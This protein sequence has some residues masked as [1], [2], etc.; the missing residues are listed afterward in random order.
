MSKFVF[1]FFTYSVFVVFVAGAFGR[2]MFASE[3]A[4]NSEISLNLEDSELF[5]Y[6]DCRLVRQ[7]YL[8][9]YLYIVVLD[10]QRWK[11]FK[12]YRDAVIE[13]NSLHAQWDC[14]QL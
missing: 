6:S 11:V 8:S 14:M 7:Y 9:R 12:N 10:G 2:P 4:E 5:E 13:L 3:L 1:S